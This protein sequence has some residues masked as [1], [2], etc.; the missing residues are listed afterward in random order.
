MAAEVWAWTTRPIVESIK[1]MFA[2]T[3]RDVWH[4]FVESIPDLAGYGTMAAGGFIILGSMVGRGGIAKPLAKLAAGLIV[5]VCI[6][7]A[8]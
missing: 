7:E 8:A 2:N 6:L 3:G 1:A 4:W 5:A